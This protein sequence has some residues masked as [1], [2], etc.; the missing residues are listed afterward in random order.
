MLKSVNLVG[1]SYEVRLLNNKNYT[2]LSLLNSYTELPTILYAPQ[3]NYK[4]LM[5]N[6]LLLS[7][8]FILVIIGCTLVSPSDGWSLS[9]PYFSSILL[10]LG[11]RR[12]SSRR[13]STSLSK[14]SWKTHG[15]IPSSYSYYCPLLPVKKM[16]KLFIYNFPME[17]DERFPM[18]W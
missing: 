15:Q 16:Y 9:P 1:I 8:V 4:G 7:T 13:A 11:A 17:L 14:S 3:K 2:S 18:P 5:K 10:F 12:P 6:S